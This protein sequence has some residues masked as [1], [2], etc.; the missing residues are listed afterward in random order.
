MTNAADWETIDMTSDMT[1]RDYFEAAKVRYYKG[2][3]S[4]LECSR[5]HYD[6][7]LNSV[8][9]IHVP[10]ISFAMGEPHT[11]NDLDEAVYHCFIVRD[12]R[13]L[14]RMASVREIKAEHPG[15]TRMY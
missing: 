15:T 3:R 14:C 9:P 10:G 12:G 7:A 13:Y 4:W 1:P 6:N 8:P 11:H 5:E 2:D